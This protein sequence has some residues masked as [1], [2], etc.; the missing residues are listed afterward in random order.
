MKAEHDAAMA[1]QK[2]NF[3]AEIAK[4]EKE[5]EA[6]LEENAV[7]VND[8]R[9]FA[10]KANRMLLLA[11]HD[12]RRAKESYI[13]QAEHLKEMEAQEKRCVKFLKAM[14]Q[15]LSGKF[16]LR[17]PSEVKFFLG[18]LLTIFSFGFHRSLP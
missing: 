6:E 13:L 17:I 15:Q 3:E 2:E 11:K 9:I 12:H 14:D 5:H 4:M 7:Q 1:K 10:R 8:A 16:S 18:S